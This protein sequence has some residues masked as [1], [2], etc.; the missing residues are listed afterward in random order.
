MSV[1]VA[2]KCPALAVYVVAPSRT[3]LESDK[4]QRAC[5]YSLN[6]IL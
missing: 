6:A 2:I 4:S 3:V 5:D 1:H